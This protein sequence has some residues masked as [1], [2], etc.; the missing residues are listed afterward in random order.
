MLK[1]PSEGHTFGNGKTSGTGGTSASIRQLLK[2]IRDSTYT[3]PKLIKMLKATLVLGFICSNPDWETL[4]LY[5]GIPQGIQ[6]PAL[7]KKDDGLNKMADR[8]NSDKDPEELRKP[9]S[10]SIDNAKHTQADGDFDKADSQ[11]IAHLRQEAPFKNRVNLA[12]GKA[13]EMLPTPCFNQ[14][15]KETTSYNA[16]NLHHGQRAAQPQT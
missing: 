9:P 8:D 7:N 13:R 1:D 14:L 2:R 15:G 11:H 16:N 6:G 10:S 4:A 3:T 5:L 12:V